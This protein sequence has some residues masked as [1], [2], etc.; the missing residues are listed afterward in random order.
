MKKIS[1]IV[2]VCCLSIVS[3]CAQ[4]TQK[5]SVG[6]FNS[7]DV[8]CGIQVLLTEGSSSSVTVE[9]N[10][11]IISDVKTEVKGR[12]LN[13]SF[14]NQRNKNNK[15]KIVVHVTAKDIE[16]LDSG[17]GSKIEGTNTINAGNIKLNVN[18]AGQINLDLKANDVVC[19]GNSAGTIT[20]RGE[21]VSVKAS[22]NSASSFNLKGFQTTN[23]DISTNSGASVDITVKSEIKAH[24]NSGAHV[25]Y[26]GNPSK[27][28]ISSNSGASVKR[29]Q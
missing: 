11:N 2:F 18:S 27:T 20:L 7:I 8:C 6:S 9:A 10:S 28:D 3:L 17:S 4:T 5:R 15:G 21:A 14:N 1:S 25:R 16:K 23:A 24:A 13:I 29:A 19:N 12:T 22:N 26:Y